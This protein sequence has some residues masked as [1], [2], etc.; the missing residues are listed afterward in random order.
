MYTFSMKIR[1]HFVK[2]AVQFFTLVSTL[3]IRN[4]LLT[5]AAAGSYG[6]LCSLVPIIMLIAGI[7]IR[8]FNTTPDVLINMLNQTSITQ[9]F[10]LQN[11][12]DSIFY[13]KKA[14]LFEIIITLFVLW[15]ARRF[16][17]YLIRG[18]RQIFRDV[19][20]QRPLLAGIITF[21]SEVLL[22]LGVA[23][24]IFVLNV[25]QTFMNVTGL[26]SYAPWFLKKSGE[27][28][29][30]IIPVVMMFIVIMMFYHFVPG[31]KPK[32]SYC[33]IASVFC[34]LSFW[35]FDMFFHLFLNM[36]RYNIVYGFLS[37]LIVL[38]LEVY[39][40]FMLLLFFAECIFVKQFYAI[41][42]FEQL[43]LLPPVTSRKPV[44][45]F[46]RFVFKEPES[47]LDSIGMIFTKG[48]NIFESETKSE[49]I[50]YIVSGTI[51]YFENNHIEYYSGGT[52]FGEIDCMTKSRRK[53]AAVAETDVTLFCISY[54]TFKE[55]LD[56]SSE[57]NKKMV[58]TMNDFYSRANSNPL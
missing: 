30:N 37:N 12:M 49:C 39:V 43:Y 35:V 16:F 38:M 4:D 11:V 32:F 51:S 3:F 23:L 44:D 19:V 48:Q 31:S 9:A 7:L 25:F 56:F 52:F 13:V 14:G 46:T 53:S 45:A 5:Y 1:P 17:N 26:V 18:F 15:M 24:L 54:E 41:L 58:D 10:D 34:T 27:L 40:F 55:L 20:P 47:V 6:F 28:F 57:S 22:V 21:S 36:G 29:L 42:S 50:Y 2:R 8:F 33:G